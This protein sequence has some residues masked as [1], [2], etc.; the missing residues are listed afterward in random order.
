MQSLGAKMMR[1]VKGKMMRHLPQMITCVE[2]EDF[3]VD[4]LEDRLSDRQRKRFEFHLRFCRECR[5]YLAA[6]QCARE[7][8]HRALRAAD[9]ELPEIP[10][11]LVT[12]VL[13]SRNCD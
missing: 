3:I 6:Y 9:E 7:L 2:F 10:E 12:A 4:Y 1:F 11:D 8:A 13:D 5:E